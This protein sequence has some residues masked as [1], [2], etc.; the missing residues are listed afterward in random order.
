MG[1]GVRADKAKAIQLYQKAAEQGL[2]QAQFNLGVCYYNGEGVARDRTAA[3]RWLQ[4]A[5]DQGYEKAKEVMRKY[6]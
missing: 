5:A 3:K 6:F 1:E 4:R 2:A